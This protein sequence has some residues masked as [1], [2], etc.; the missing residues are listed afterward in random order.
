[1]L[2]YSHRGYAICPNSHSGLHCR[3][4]IGAQIFLGSFLSGHEFQELWLVW[5]SKEKTQGVFR[6]S[7]IGDVIE[8]NSFFSFNFTLN[9]EER[10]INRE[11][12]MTINPNTVDEDSIFSP[13][14]RVKNTGKSNGKHFQGF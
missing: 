14:G 3:A 4:G 6:K 5:D 9:V 7:L 12:T 11:E 13:S 8:R 1:M 10:T 2:E